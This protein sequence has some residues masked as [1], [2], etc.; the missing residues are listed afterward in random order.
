MTQTIAQ[1]SR[2]LSYTLVGGLMTLTLMGTGVPVSYRMDDLVTFTG[3]VSF[4]PPSSIEPVTLSAQIYESPSV[5]VGGRP[6]ALEPLSTRL[7]KDLR[8]A[9]GFTWEQLSKLLG[10]SRRSLHLWSA[11]GRMA[12]A[13][14]EAVV[15]LLQNV[16]ALSTVDPI[17]RRV[18]LLAILDRARAAQAS[19]SQDINRPA[20]TYTGGTGTEA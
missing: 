10:V 5:Q 17:Q 9:T 18:E 13:N 3:I 16:D 2:P 19:T 8:A 4:Q 14:E 12:A 7:I 6:E 20:A 11:G 15:R 1:E